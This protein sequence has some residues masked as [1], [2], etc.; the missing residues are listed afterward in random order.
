MQTIFYHGWYTNVDYGLDSLTAD[1][2]QHNGM[3]L[4]QNLY[5]FHWTENCIA[6][7]LGNVHGESGLNPGST[8]RPRPWG[9]YLPDNEEVLESS[10]LRG[11]G[12]TQWTPG[13]DKIVQF[14]EDT[15]RIWYDGITQVFRLKWECDNGEQM[16]G[17]QWF[18]HNTGDPADLAEYFLRQYERPTP[19]Q[20]EATLPTRRRYA[21][22]W[23]D[24][25]H[26]KLVNPMKWIYTQQNRKRKE[27]KRRCLRV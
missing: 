5:N 10:Y 8:E 25:I 4:A 11:M 17:W 12:F 14:A 2:I 6:G 13:R 19:E 22:M 20:I 3:K 9:D 23:Y 15:H 26:G 16:G 21:T 18:I 7:I 24:R 1:E 27:L